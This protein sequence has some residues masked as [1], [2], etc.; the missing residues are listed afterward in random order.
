MPF[1]LYNA[2]ATVEKQ[3]EMELRELLWKSCLIYLDD[4]IAVGNTFSDHVSNLKYVFKRLHSANLN[5]NPMKCQLFQ[6]KGKCMRHIVDSEM[7]RTLMKL[8]AP[9]D[10]NELRSFLG[11][12]TYYRRFVLGLANIAEPLTKLT[13]EGR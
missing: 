3:M 12:C 5:L 2:P 10:K 1:G 8:P 9:K 6:K 7:S 11:L 13:K 4:V